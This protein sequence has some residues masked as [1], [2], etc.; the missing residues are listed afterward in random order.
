MMFNPF[1]KQES[2]VSKDGAPRDLASVALSILPASIRKSVAVM[3]GVGLLAQ[4]QNSAVAAGTPS[5]SSLPAEHRRI[6][7]TYNTN[8]P[9]RLRPFIEQYEALIRAEVVPSLNEAKKSAVKAGDIKGAEELDKLEKAWMALADAYRGNKTQVTWSEVPK[10]TLPPATQAKIDALR[11]QYDQSED[12][13]NSLYEQA[14]GRLVAAAQQAGDLDGVKAAQA[15][16]G[17]KKDSVTAQVVGSVVASIVP[18][19][20][21]VS[22]SQPAAN[23]ESV[24]REVGWSG[25]VVALRCY[26]SVDYYVFYESGVGVRHMTHK[27]GER[28]EFSWTMAKSGGSEDVEVTEKGEKPVLFKMAGAELSRLVPTKDGTYSERKDVSLVE[29]PRS[30]PVVSQ[31]IDK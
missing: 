30:V 5:L 3:V 27:G 9:T 14:V 29:N 15:L 2:I 21:K 20:G 31:L 12:S 25:R 19:V 8:L 24:G 6:V 10:T 1:S 18:E 13:F 28:R 7:D 17:F 11:T 26:G 23:P 4:A 22:D 16:L